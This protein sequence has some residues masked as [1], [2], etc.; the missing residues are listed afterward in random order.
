[1]DNYKNKLGDLAN[2]L[3]K[4]RPATPVQQVLPVRTGTLE[5]APEV[6]FNNWIPKAL[7]KRVKAYGV[8]YDLS[9]KD[10][11]ILALEAYLDQKAKP[12]QTTKKAI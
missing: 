11:N 3:M 9:L 5:K 2:K 6:Q 10:I 12:E 4:E 8:E 1:M 7:L